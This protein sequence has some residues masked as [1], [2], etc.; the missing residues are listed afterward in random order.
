MELAQRIELLHRSSQRM[1]DSLVI[2]AAKDRD[3]VWWAVM[4][5]EAWIHL[6]RSFEAWW[7]VVQGKE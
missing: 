6:K 2:K 5:K 7:H 1:M 3:K 4:K